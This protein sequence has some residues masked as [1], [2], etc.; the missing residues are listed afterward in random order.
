MTVKKI[1][2]EHL[3]ANGYDGLCDDYFN[4]D[5]FIDNLMPCKGDDCRVEGCKPGYKK[6]C[7]CGGQQHWHI[8][9]TKPDNRPKMDAGC[10]L[11]PLDEKDEP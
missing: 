7:N 4:C 3:E 2:A 9:E 8:Y 1:I 10:L 6:S 11:E 5:C